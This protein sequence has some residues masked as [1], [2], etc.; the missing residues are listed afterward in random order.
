MKEMVEVLVT[1]GRTFINACTTGL[2]VI[3][4]KHNSKPLNRFTSLAT[5][6]RIKQPDL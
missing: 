6:S 4:A 2:A 1:K 3:T 5:K